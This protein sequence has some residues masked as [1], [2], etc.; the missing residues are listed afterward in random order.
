MVEEPGAVL[1][2]ARLASLVEEVGD[3]G[4]VRAAVATFVDEVPLRL[5]GISAALAGDDLDHV[6]SAAHALGSPAAMLGAVAV[7]T[8]TRA[9]DD[10]AAQGRVEALRPL[11]R[12]VA[13]DAA[14]TVAAMRAYLGAAGPS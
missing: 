7:R 14:R 3:A 13:S 2:T 10:A 1:D 11:S 5:D 6:R 4:I 12:R 9:L 8:S